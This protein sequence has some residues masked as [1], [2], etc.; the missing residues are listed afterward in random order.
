MT[1]VQRQRHRANLLLLLL[2][3]AFVGSV[4][5]RNGG[6]VWP[7]IFITLEASL[8]AACADWFAITALFRRPLGLPIPHTAILPRKHEEIGDALGPLIRSDLLP[9]ETV[10]TFINTFE[11][12]NLLLHWANKRSPDEI[13]DGLLSWLRPQPGDRLS[14]PPQLQE[15]IL[16]SLR[17]APVAAWL[18][19][20]LRGG[21]GRA[22][23]NPV[24]DHLFGW[25]TDCLKSEECAALLQKMLKKWKGEQMHSETAPGLQRFLLHLA[26]G[27]GALNEADA[28]RDV[29]SVVER[30]L[31]AARSCADHELRVAL[32]AW[33]G[34][35]A[36]DL[37]NQTPL[38]G[39]IDAWWKEMVETM[40]L[41]EPIQ[42]LVRHLSSDH[43]LNSLQPA[44][45]D[46][47]NRTLHSLRQ[48]AATT[49][50]LNENTRALLLRLLE[51]F[52]ELLDPFVKY[53]FT[54]RFP[55]TALGQ[56][57]EEEVG[58][59]LQRLRITGTIVGGIAGLVLALL[60]RS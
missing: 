34:Q 4:P 30:E 29:L 3:V 44:L 47:L 2:A 6:G 19:R 46:A 55:A 21:S 20:L 25:F 56:F 52:Y 51:P 13:A 60:T 11:P 22:D 27:T 5:F 43:T 28:A 40:D 24:L 9:L 37:Q 57:V 42:D 41:Q 1:E 39:E 59:L 35:M 50:R 54:Q 48:D 8:A 16:L 53:V 32:R 38:A 49:A 45:T 7:W 15:F 10:Q 12:V 58:D 33:T 17:R 14:P 26:E 18:G 31:T 23:Q 36:H